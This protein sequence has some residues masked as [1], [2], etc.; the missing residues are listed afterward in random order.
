MAVGI[1]WNSN[2]PAGSK[3]GARSSFLQQPADSGRAAFVLRRRAG[4][5]AE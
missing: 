1:P 3:T 5:G 2:D 4:G